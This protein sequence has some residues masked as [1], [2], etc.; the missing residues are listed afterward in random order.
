V[1]NYNLDADRGYGWIN[2]NPK[3]TTFPNSGNVD[4]VTEL[5]V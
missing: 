2:W 1:A 4:A 3:K 5:D